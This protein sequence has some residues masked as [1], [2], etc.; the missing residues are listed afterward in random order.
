MIGLKRIPQLQDLEEAYGLLQ[1]AARNQSVIAPKKLALL[2]QWTRFDPRLGEQLVSHLGQS[3]R[4]LEPLNLNKELC[5]QPWPPAMGVILLKVLNYSITKSNRPLF[6]QWTS[7]VMQGIK[8]ACN[9]QFF[10]GLRSLGGPLMLEDVLRSHKSYR[11]WG[12]FGREHLLNKAD[13]TLAIRHK[14]DN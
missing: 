2:S 1:S 12:Y 5:R 6:K 13:Y 8:P 11:R 3:W 9:E 10:I 4:K 14:K 7:L